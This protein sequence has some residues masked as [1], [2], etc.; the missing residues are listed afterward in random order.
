MAILGNM[1]QIWKYDENCNVGGSL[2]MRQRSQ[3]E[4]ALDSWQAGKSS[5]VTVT[6][7]T[8]KFHSCMYSPGTSDGSMWPGPSIAHKNLWSHWSGHYR[9][10]SGL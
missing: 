3:I 1:D 2:T 7:I 9:R 8:H 5:D 4:S 6:L 10:P